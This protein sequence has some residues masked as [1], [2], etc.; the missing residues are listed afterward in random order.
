MSFD[1]QM[2]D[3]LKTFVIESL[4]LLQDMEDGLLGLEDDPEPSERINAIFRAA[5]TIKGSSGLFGLDH[6]VAFTHVVESVLDTLRDGKLSVSPELVAILLP[7]C[8]H[9]IELI[10]AVADGN[11][12][13]N[14]S[15][16][17]AERQLLDGLESFLKP[18]PKQVVTTVQ[19]AGEQFEASGGGVIDSGNWHLFIQFGE[20]CLRDGM[21]PL[22]FIRY[23]ATLG[24]IMSLTTFSHAMPDAE[25]MDP[26]SSYL[27]FEIV[28]KSDADKA[29]IE[30]VF[31]FVRDGSYIH[32]LPLE[33]KIP[34]YVELINSLGEDNSQL[35]ELLLK[36]GVITQRELQEGLNVQQAQV[37][38]PNTRLG[39]ILVDQQVVQ[40]P[41]VNAALEKQQ[42]IKDN[43]ARENQTIR[44]DAE[45]LDKLIDVI[46]EL[47]ISGAGVNLRALQT[48]DSALLEATSEM[49]RLVEEV[50]DGALQLRMVAIGA[51]FS[52]FQRV[53]RDVGKE[54]GKDISL[55]I[56]GGDT[57]VDKSVVEKIGDPL[58]H[59]VRNAMDHGI[60]SAEV[61]AARGKSSRGELRL[62]AYHE[63]GSIAIEVSDDGGGLDRD[64]ILAKAIE[65]GL[66]QPDAK[67]SD[68]EIYSLIFEPGFST[69]SQISNLSGRGVGMDVV[70]RN[71][72]DL[73]GDIEVESRPGQGST[74]RIRLPLTLAIIDGFLVGVGKSSYVIPLDR[75]VECL[76][77][78]GDLN[79]RDYM[80]LRGEVLPF[81]R[82]RNLF[83]IR[84]DQP[85]RPNVVVVHAAG[86]KTGLV[87][88]RLIGE[89][90]TVIKPLGKLFGHVEGLGGST[91]LGSGEVALILDV[92]VLVSAFEHKLQGNM[93][94]AQA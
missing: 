60:E 67:L 46:G 53:V 87:V 70:K 29:T 5:H 14:P 24:E 69:A 54:L 66:V 65:K 48:S 59:L 27:G 58:M 45:R 81:I 74:I 9:M 38:Q 55:V 73:R 79:D 35:G 22:S 2:R 94:L 34:Y 17:N 3:A 25:S 47:V 32:I 15:M 21:D 61:R 51:T 23:L 56:T 57:E 1:D 91:I 77:L 13:T 18:E 82:L 10:Q 20:N 30:A 80:D 72:T 93:H 43:K 39:E 90:Q 71:V 41:L 42:Q 19:Q 26:E 4:E 62:N 52:R 44:V 63:S 84:G 86:V 11:V 50:R 8:D 89:F 75:V 83:N 37:P 40:Q 76:E 6:I 85:R 88:D 31:D 12:S 33:D 68:Q 64:R 7:C 28:L 78:S 36:S 92:P 16:T 49:M